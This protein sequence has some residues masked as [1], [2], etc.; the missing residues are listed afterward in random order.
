MTQFDGVGG[1]DIHGQR[2]TLP[3]ELEDGRIPHFFGSLTI[4]FSGLFLAALVWASFAE[5]REL[6]VSQGEIAPYGQVQKIEHLE[7]GQIQTIFYHEGERVEQGDVLVQ[8]SPI[9]AAADL[10]QLHARAANLRLRKEA[11]S[12]LI[13]GR[14]PNVSAMAEAFPELAA[15]QMQIYTSKRLQAVEEQGAREA[16]VLQ[17][18]NAYEAV[19]VD[20]QSLKNQLV[21]SEEQLAIQAEL[22]KSG[23]V[24]RATYLD[25][26]AT[27][28]N[29]RSQTLA[30]KGRIDVARE[31][32]S[33][34][35]HT[36]EG[37][38]AQSMN[39]FGEERGE[40]NIEL[41]ELEQQ[42]GKFAD[43][44]DRLAIRSPV[45]GTV[46]EIVQKT[47]GEVIRPGDL[48]ATI[49]PLDSRVVAEVRVNPQDIG[50]IRK[51][52]EVEV[53]LSTFDPNVFG[54][55]KGRVGVISASTF[56]N[57]NNEPYYKAIIHLDQSY[58]GE[59]IK[60]RAI[61]PGMIVQADIITGSKSLIQYILKP[62]YRSLDI[63][64]SER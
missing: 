39:Q 49:V 25:Y 23:L 21:I 59:G 31:Q 61:Q 19:I 7:G 12:A 20:A 43:R 29:F 26:E 6:A 1:P 37:N 2:F 53:K 64:F 32:L 9:A 63:G 38:A 36:L 58:V 27:Y 55:I 17:R 10:K 14:E 13:E 46:Q 15:D 33:V 51:D 52:D 60:R 40:V 41:A 47:P 5:I 56:K 28:E 54:V 24:A 22:L 35:R 48:V 11:L 42:I 50:H 34:A 3:A 18:K 45:R 57:E 30:A 44:V 4:L 16:T 8:L 62:V